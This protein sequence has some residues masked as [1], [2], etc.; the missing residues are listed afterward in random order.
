MATS[1]FKSQCVFEAERGGRLGPAWR[2]RMKPS[3]PSRPPEGVRGE[4]RRG[5]PGLRWGWPA[6]GLLGLQAAAWAPGVN[7][8]RQCGSCLI[9]VQGFTRSFLKKHTGIPNCCP[10]PPARPSHLARC[11][12]LVLGG[13]RA[14][15]EAAG[16]GRG[17]CLFPEDGR[18]RASPA[19]SAAFN[20]A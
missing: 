8:S 13:P 3:A 12:R 18:R 15:T 9:K 6:G 2:P 19:F 11:P 17:S 20:L 16:P 4:A 14:G 7:Q 10:R 5:C 1:A